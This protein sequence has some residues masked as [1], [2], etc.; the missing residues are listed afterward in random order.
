MMKDKL[1]KFFS[2]ETVA[3]IIAYTLVTVYLAAILTVAVAI[4]V[5]SIKGI[6]WCFG[7]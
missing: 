4:V 6:I 3:S 7:G 1:R 2:H 5:F